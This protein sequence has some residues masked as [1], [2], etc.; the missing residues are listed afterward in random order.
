MFWFGSL[1]Q[2]DDVYFI[3]DI[4]L[5]KI[6]SATPTPT[7]TLTPMPTPTPPT[8][9]VGI[10]SFSSGSTI[11]GTRTFWANGSA[12]LS[13]LTFKFFNTVTNVFSSHVIT[14]SPSTTTAPDAFGN[15]NYWLGSLDTTKLSNGSYKLIAKGIYNGNPYENTA[16]FYFNVSNPAV[17]TSVTP[18]LSVSPFPTYNPNL[19][20]SHFVSNNPQISPKIENFP[21]ECQEKGYTTPEAC[22]KYFQFPPECR[23]KNILN[24]DQCRQLMFQFSMPPECRDAGVKTQEE[25]SK[26][27]FSRSLPQECR[28][29]NAISEDDCNKV[30][31]VK[32][33]P[34]E[35]VEA[36]IFDRDECGKFIFK[37][38]APPE[39]LEQG[40]STPEE[41]EK[42]MVK[43]YGN[44]DNIKP[45]NLPADCQKAGATS[46][47]ECDKIMKDKYMPQDCKDQKIT[48]AG[49]CDVYLSRKNMPAECKDAG[50]KT[51]E[52]CDKVMFKKFSPEP[53]KKAGIENEKECKDYMFNLYAPKV[54]CDGLNSWDCNKEIKENHLGNIV[55]KQA[56]YNKIKEKVSS[57]SGTSAS[58]EKIKEKVGQD[59]KMISLTENTVVLKIVNA[60]EKMVLN[61]EDDLVQTAPIIVAVD[62]DGDG[63]PDDTEKRIGTDPNNRDTDND[64]LSDN[65]EVKNS[66]DPLGAGNMPEKMKDT[67]SP[68]D[69]ALIQ[70][71]TLGHP[72]TDGVES[73]DLVVDSVVSR[74]TGE[75]GSAG[76]GYSLTG[77]AEK[78]SVVTIYIYSDFPVVATVKTDEFGNWQY[79]F[80][81]S[82]IDGEHEVYVAVNDNTGKVVNKSQPLSFFINEAKAVSVS[83]FISLQNTV[84]P[85]ESEKAITSYA[86]IALI[87]IVV[88][89]IGF[90]FAIIKR[91]KHTAAQ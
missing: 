39:C 33:G 69:W 11:S 3:D 37:K 80:D 48:D 53:C 22:Q 55:A 57:L 16:N 63:L 2:A 79:E 54:V 1:A 60:D 70:D 84:A 67:I 32:Y 17:N 19:S 66:S 23:E 89:I 20:P 15:Y 56:D 59:N 26:I 62:S 72:T 30:M 87:A 75:T 43:K 76:N 61:K 44:L 88:G 31:F 6:V 65:E 21:S 5:E 71:K 83:D 35:C 13:A 49:Q 29:A 7:L 28:D 77:K 73:E 46:V 50:A 82:L 58:I 40:I 78:N 42:Y 4:M 86:F 25:C 74:G 14:G 24:E 52:D 45:D 8:I 9:T 12:P 68:V 85:K 34:K 51:R 36:N 47:D 91:K 38:N 81:K 27:I 64:G 41:C 10:N 90:V 18:V